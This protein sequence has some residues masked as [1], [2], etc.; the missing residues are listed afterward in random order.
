MLAFIGHCRRQLASGGHT[1]VNAINLPD[2]RPLPDVSQLPDWNRY[3]DPEKQLRQKAASVRRGKSDRVVAVSGHFSFHR[4]AEGIRC[5]DVA[6]TADIQF[7]PAD[8]VDLTGYREL[9]APGGAIK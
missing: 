1:W 8:M 4:G 7:P 3:V 9:N 2:H 6:C 5:Q